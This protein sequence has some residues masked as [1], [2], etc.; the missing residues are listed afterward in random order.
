MQPSSAPE[1]ID[2]GENLAKFWKEKYLNSL[3]DRLSMVPRIPTDVDGEPASPM[4]APAVKTDARLGNSRSK[5]DSPERTGM[6]LTSELGM[7]WPIVVAVK[8]PEMANLPTRVR[9]KIDTLVRDHFLTLRLGTVAANRESSAIPTIRHEM[10]GEFIAWFDKMIQDGMIE[11]TTNMLDVEMKPMDAARMSIEAVLLQHE[12]SHHLMMTHEGVSPAAQAREA[13]I[14][15]AAPPQTVMKQHHYNPLP[16]IVINI[17]AL[18][19]S[20]SASSPISSTMIATSPI[21][22]NAPQRQSSLPPAPTMTTRA[23]TPRQ[24]PIVPYDPNS[25]RWIAWT[26]IVRQRFPDWSGSTPA[27]SNFAKA[28]LK[29]HRLPETRVSPLTGITSKPTLGIP[30]DLQKSFMDGFDRRFR[31]QNGEWVQE[32]RKGVIINLHPLGDRDPDAL[33]I[34]RA[35]KPEKVQYEKVVRT[36]SFPGHIITRDLPG[37][38]RSGGSPMKRTSSVSSVGSV[39]SSSGTRLGNTAGDFVLSPTETT[40]QRGRYLVKLWTDVIRGKHEAFLL[41]NVRNVSLQTRV[42]NGVK[43]FI[44]K[45]APSLDL[46][47]ESCLVTSD[48]GRQSFGIP[49]VL[50]PSF[51]AWFED[52]RKTAFKKYSDGTSV[53]DLFKNDELQSSSSS[54]NTLGNSLARKR[55]LGR[56]NVRSEQDDAAAMDAFAMMSSPTDED[57]PMENSRAKRPR[58]TM[59]QSYELYI[60]ASA[61]VLDS[62]LSAGLTPTPTAMDREDSPFPLTRYTSLVKQMMPNY[63]DLPKSTRIAIKKSAKNFLIATI[64]LERLNE[65]IVWPKK[66]IFQ[67]YSIP[68]HLHNA[69]YQW[70]GDRF[71][72][73][74]APAGG[75]NLE[76]GAATAQQDEQEEAEV[77]TPLVREDSVV[78]DAVA[79]DVDPTT[80]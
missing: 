78:Q 4:L 30:K 54:N 21:V 36:N 10:Q 61:D 62:P 56:S 79:M 38:R 57:S 17:P 75:R 46:T 18:S 55:L 25:E 60:A 29:E 12:P 53:S 9:S 44:I 37:Q 23:P 50:I 67:T 34:V 20:I 3:E 65:C 70:I 16:P 40:E 13:V 32:R 42:R 33:P 47:L 80:L 14:A 45:N 77:S 73:Y 69:F 24:H 51:L 5:G 49:D 31:T 35:H 27:M 2:H 8:Y 15:P 66:G 11:T 41:D 1:T 68:Y 19:P 43:D 74:C 7:E 72:Q 52:E 22:V 48:R 26:D 28:F 63:A 39:S 6:S 58:L 59:D 64:G 76:I 71:S